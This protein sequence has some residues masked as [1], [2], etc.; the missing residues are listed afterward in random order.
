M[1]NCLRMAFRSGT[2]CFAACLVLACDKDQ[3]TEPK[4]LEVSKISYQVREMDVAVGS[5]VTQIDVPFVV[6]TKEAI[7]A[8][9]G[10]VGTI[11]Y[12]RT[13]A[14]KEWHYAFPETEPATRI[15]DTT[16]VFP[17]RL[18]PERITEP[19]TLTLCGDFPHFGDRTLPFIDTLTIRLTPKRSAEE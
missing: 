19:L 12:D 10:A 3:A 16:Y 8:G 7:Y 5:E 13:T 1:Y 2:A 9:K 11:D 6:I 15:D 14:V 18:F 17:I 4:E